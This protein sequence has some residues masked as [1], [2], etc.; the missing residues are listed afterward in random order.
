MVFNDKD[1][2]LFWVNPCNKAGKWIVVL[3]YRVRQDQQIIMTLPLCFGKTLTSNRSRVPN[4]SGHGSKTKIVLQSVKGKTTVHC[5]PLNYVLSIEV[6]WA[7]SNK[8]V[9]TLRSRVV[10]TCRT[11]KIGFDRWG[12]YC[13]ST[14]FHYRNFT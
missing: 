8:V 9:F 3:R 12:L 6:N 1:F 7:V 4:W 13:G 14:V 2:K 10:A 5:C 11:Q